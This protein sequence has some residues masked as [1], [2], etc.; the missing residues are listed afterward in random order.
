MKFDERT[1]LLTCFDTRFNQRDRSPFVQM[2][3]KFTTR[4]TLH[5]VK[6]LIKIVSPASEPLQQKIVFLRVYPVRRWKNDFS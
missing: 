3:C 4:P 1:Y 6:E 5:T 2:V